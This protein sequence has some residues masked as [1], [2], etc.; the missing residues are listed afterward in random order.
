ML[1][2]SEAPRKKLLDRRINICQV[3]KDAK[4]FPNFKNFFR[5]RLNIPLSCPLKA[6]KIEF[7]PNLEELYP[8]EAMQIVLEIK[9]LSTAM[10]LRNLQL[11]HDMKFLVFTK[12]KNIMV[13]VLTIYDLDRRVPLWDLSLNKWIET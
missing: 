10:T 2:T 5:S 8:I 9:Q 1:E 4:K 13:N 11:L 3:L 12:L 6:G 7:V